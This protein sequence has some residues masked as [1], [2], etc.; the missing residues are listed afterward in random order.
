MCLGMWYVYVCACSNTVNLG[1]TASIVEDDPSVWSLTLLWSNRHPEGFPR[2]SFAEVFAQH[3]D[4]RYGSKS[5]RSLD[6][7]KHR[8]DLGSLKRNSRLFTFYIVGST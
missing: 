1:V 8:D 3:K 4:S 6:A 7:T 2:S 5:S